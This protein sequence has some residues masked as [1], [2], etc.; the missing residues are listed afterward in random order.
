[1]KQ[2]EYRCENCGYEGICYV[3]PT[4]QGCSA[5]WCPKC[6]RNHKLVKIDR[7]SNETKM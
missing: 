7:R 3:Q 4:S 5:P 2:Q 6:Q 1:M